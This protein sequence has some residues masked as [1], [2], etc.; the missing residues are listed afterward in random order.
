MSKQLFTDI[1]LFVLVSLFISLPAGG[2]EQKVQP[3]QAGNAPP[4]LFSGKEPVEITSKRLT[5]RNGKAV[6]EGNVVV[7]Q[8]DARLSA[9]WMEVE[10]SG[11]GAIENIHAR[12]NVLLK[13][14]GR[15]ISSSEALYYRDRGTVVFTG[16][17]VARAKTSTISGSRMVYFIE[18]GRSVVENSKVIIRNE[19]GD[20]DLDNK[21]ENP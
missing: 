1:L 20:K 17:P 18:D 15:E 6:F 8:G 3:V 14:D 19:D 5:A 16:N 9:D 10:Y 13:Q 21:N 11:K 7:K 12:G 4:V 2:A